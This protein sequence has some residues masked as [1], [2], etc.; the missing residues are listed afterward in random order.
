M[1]IG[2]A[3]QQIGGGLVNWG[4]KRKDN[5][6]LQSQQQAAAQKEQELY[7]QRLLALQRLQAPAEKVDQ[8]YN[9]QLGK[10][11]NVRRQWQLNPEGTGGSWV[12]TG[13]DIAAPA[14]SAPKFEKY[15]VGDE[16]VAALV[17][18]AT[19]E[20]KE[21]GRGNA[22]APSQRRAGGGRG[23]GSGRGK[24][25]SGFRYTEEGD[26]EAIPGGPADLKR[27]A[28]EDKAATLSSADKKNIGGIR[29][30]LG[31]LDAIEAQLNSAEEAWKP[32]RG[33]FAAGVGGSYVPTE[34]G[35]KFDANIAQFGP[36]IRS[37]TRVPGEGATS[38]RETAALERGLPSRGDY[39][40]TTDEKLKNYRTLLK[41]MREARL[42]N[43]DVYGVDGNGEPKAKKEPNAAPQRES[44]QPGSSRNSPV[45]IKS[46]AEAD[47]LPPGTWV[48]L[49]GRLGQT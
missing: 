34:A 48:M 27:Q 11:Q 21:L 2:A 7:Q 45:Q 38:D 41:E 20:V 29:Q 26:L 49:N 35:K 10:V 17:D 3:L 43:L 25:P 13:R 14:P 39:E 1:G 19:G 28:A 46:E 4:M 40:S 8:F 12:E 15:R 42:A 23:G 32:L 5:Q 16:E 37:L 44:G 9:E 31:V 18:P 22:F 36:L 24:A 30:S 47:S 6:E 33:S